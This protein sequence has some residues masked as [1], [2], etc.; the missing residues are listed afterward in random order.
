MCAT[1]KGR[2]AG[3][4]LC[5]SPAL[6]A[7]PSPP[8]PTDLRELAECRHAVERVL[9]EQR[10]WPE[11][12]P[13]PRPAFDAWVT[14]E[15]VAEQM[16]DVL[17]RA[18]ALDKRWQ[19]PVDQQALKQ[20]VERM[21]QSSG[22]RDLLEAMFDAAG[23]EERA[24]LCVAMPELVL[25]E[26]DAAFAAD[27]QVHGPRRKMLEDHLEAGMPLPLALVRGKAT[28][29]DRIRR[30]PSGPDALDGSLPPEALQALLDRFD[31]AGDAVDGE[32][33]GAA[34]L[35]RDGK[36]AHIGMRTGLEERRQV[37]VLQEVT[38]ADDDTVELATTVWPKQPL[39][40][41]WSHAR[42]EFQAV[43]PRFEIGEQALAKNTS[44]LPDPLL[45][46]ARYGQAA[47][48]TG[49]EMIIWGGHDGVVPVAD[50]YRYTPATNSWV[51]LTDFNA[52]S[53]RWLPSVVWTGLDVIIWGGASTT[54]GGV[55]PAD[56]RRFRPSTNQWDT[57]TAAPISSRYHHVAVWTGSR[58]I[59]W[60]GIENGF[61]VA[62]SGALYSPGENSWEL[63]TAP[64]PP[65]ARFRAVAVWTG[66]EMVVWGGEAGGGVHLGDGARYTP[67]APGTWTPVSAAGA[68]S[69]RSLHTAVWTGPPLNR[70]LV[71]GGKFASAS[72]LADGASYDPAGNAWTAMAA[73]GGPAA[74]YFHTAVWTG[75]EMIVWGG[76]PDNIA[77][78]STGARYAPASNTWTGPT[79]LVDAP[80]GRYIHTA[81]WS[82][83]RMIVWGGRGEGGRPFHSGGRYS[84]AADAWAG[85][86]AYAGCETVFANLVPN[87]GAEQGD[88]PTGWFRGSFEGGSGEARD[89]V[90]F[91]GGSHSLV[92]NSSS[93][94]F[95]NRQEAHIFSG[96]FPIIPNV[97]HDVGLHVLVRSEF[98]VNCGLSARISTTP[99]CQM[100][101][102]ASVGHMPVSSGPRWQRLTATLLPPESWIAARIRVTCTATL[103]SSPGFTLNVDDAYAILTPPL[104]FHDGF[105]SN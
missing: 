101:T 11:A 25:R 54:G 14:L 8:M 41:W 86:G 95:H 47:A 93:S 1:T 63:M 53:A 97:S 45:P 4:L 100:W 52:P 43:I 89:S 42:A 65:S 18:D 96:C 5:I 31:L 91:R 22:D 87:C 69:V 30:D 16:K 29:V 55:T 50:G 77:W 85:T 99:D 80:T 82:G 12:N 56:H 32:A 76:T 74:R 15:D 94:L 105:E 88:P 38:A 64:S 102:T 34:S 26:F 19:Q 40:E 57:L 20:E 98:P 2:L 58:M 81:V 49:T 46:G 27:R 9:W 39:H 35:Q 66:S 24:A 28:H 61:G 59:I 37:F 6:L 21:R 73:A 17:L 92:V 51:P 13:G 36:A 104:I 83:D 3:L 44:V 67:G 78:L 72:S 60:G 103:A 62:A 7:A 48:W 79:T 84:V 71:W 68:P 75:S 23:S 33:A 90:T 70:M 10:L